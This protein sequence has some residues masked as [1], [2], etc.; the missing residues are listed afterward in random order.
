MICSYL[1]FISP[2]YAFI[3]MMLEG[4]FPIESQVVLFGV[5]ASN[6]T[7]LTNANFEGVTV[8]P[9]LL[10][11][12]FNVILSLGEKFGGRNFG[13]PPYNAFVDFVQELGLI[14]LGFNGN[15]YTWYNKRLGH[16]KIKERLD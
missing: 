8:G 5:F 15:R 7:K 13:S 2:S 1:K 4:R 11:R 6:S 9:W 10:A 12:D 3:L 14:D 16:G